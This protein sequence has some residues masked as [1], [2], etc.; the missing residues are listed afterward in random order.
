MKK[1]F[2]LL[3]LAVSFS[4]LVT[5]CTSSESAT[6]TDVETQSPDGIPP[7]EAIPGWQTNDGIQYTDIPATMNSAP[8]HTLGQAQSVYNNMQNNVQTGYNQAVNTYNNMQQQVQSQMVPVTMPAQTP[9]MQASCQVVRDVTGA[10]IYAQIIKGCY[11]ESSYIVGKGDTMYLISYLTGQTPDQIAALNNM[12][13]DTKL[14]VGQVLRV[15]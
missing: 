10:P 15:R 3:P 14:I 4:A 5:G 13:P 2:M 6:V 11:T 12:T 9:M 1:L 8:M 7:A